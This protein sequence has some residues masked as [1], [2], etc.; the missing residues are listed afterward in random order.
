MFGYQKSMRYWLTIA[1]VFISMQLNAAENASSVNQNFEQ[2][3]SYFKQGDYSAAVEKFEQARKQGNR[4][5][6]LYY[7]L[8]SVYF[9]LG[10]YK[11]AQRYFSALKKQPKMKSLAEYNLGLIAL[12]QKDSASAKK[13]FNSIVKSGQD[14]KVIYLAN[15]QLALLGNSNRPEKKLTSKK[16]PGSVYLS[17]SLGYDSNINFAPVDIGSEESGSF[18]D[19]LVSADYLFSGKASNGWSVEGLLYTIR[20][21]DTGNP[22]IPKGAFD[23]DEYGAGL[24]KTQ[25]LAG[26]DTHIKLVLDKLTYGPRDYQSIL[27][28]EARGRYRLSKTDRVYLRY[29][30]DDISSDDA[31]FDYT[32]GWRQKIRGEFRRYNKNSYIQFY[33]ELELNDRNDLVRVDA[34]DGSISEFSYSPTRHTLR[35][36]YTAKLNKKWDLTGDLAYRKSA[37]P[38]TSTQN[39]NDDRLKAI[40]SANYRFDK[41]MKLKMKLEYTDN[42]SS[43]DLYIY[44]RQVIAVSLNKL[45]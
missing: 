13:Y 5:T 21:Q 24:K 33:Y 42:S 44:D 2:G 20:Y 11:N 34:V 38:S 39:R 10:Q 31:V 25:K 22:L 18:F 43:D 35:G 41:T 26:W 23:Q 17:G 30:Y 19:A 14:K 15:Q 28:L 12:K 45:F 1:L 29:R 36:K 3:I 4:S 40:A 27:K 32:E 8:G 7:N 9:K 37:Y 6:A 16:S